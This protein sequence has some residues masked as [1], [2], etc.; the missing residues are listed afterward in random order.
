MENVRGDKKG[1]DIKTWEVST[2][3]GQFSHV[4]QL[5]YMSHLH[6]NM[7][8]NLQGQRDEVWGLHCSRKKGKKRH[9]ILRRGLNNSMTP[10]YLKNTLSNKLKCTELMYK[11]TIKHSN[12]AQVS[13]TLH[14]YLTSI[15]VFSSLYP[16]FW[17]LL[18]VL[19]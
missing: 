9:Q 8:N 11:V 16:S 7:T 19:I 14:H 2:I 4:I 13:T 17:F 18:K 12:N 5:S 1:R 3:N 6:G 15:L 10:F